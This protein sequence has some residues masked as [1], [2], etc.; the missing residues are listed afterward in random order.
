MVE[1]LP[2]IP[3]T[4]VGDEGGFAPALKRNSDAIDLILRAIESAG[5]RP[6]DEIV[7]AI[8]PASSGF[9]ENGIYQLR[10]EGR[11]IGAQEMVALYAEW[12]RKYPIA[13]LEDGLAE[14]EGGADF[15]V[16]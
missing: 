1:D 3:A 10:T 13:V 2:T 9:F 16:I 11:A 14:D 8:D 6:G 4:G 7:L 5:Y 15:G 12:V